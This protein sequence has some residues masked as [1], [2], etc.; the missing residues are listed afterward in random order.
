MRVKCEICKKPIVTTKG[1]KKDICIMCA[2]AEIEKATVRKFYISIIPDVIAVARKSGYA[3]GVHGSLT[4]DLD[5]IGAPWIKRCV[6]PITLVKR[7]AKALDAY[8]NPEGTVRP[9]G[10]ISYL[11]YF[12]IR[13]NIPPH[14]YI[15]LSIYQKQ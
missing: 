7:L 11:I 13:E 12:K 15:D 8:Y 10:R 4:R 2:K 6:K 3:I 5:L 14:A 9:H 1:L